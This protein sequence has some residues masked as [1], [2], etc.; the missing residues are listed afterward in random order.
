MLLL[1][2]LLSG[3]I[4]PWTYMLINEPNGRIYEA[5]ISAAQFFLVGGFL[6][7]VAAFS[8]PAPSS[9]LLALSGLL[10]ALAIGTRLVIILPV[11]FLSIM[12]A[13]RLWKTARLSPLSLAGKLFSLSLP[14]VICFIGLGWYNWARFG[15][16]T[17]TGISYQ[18][19]GMNQNDANNLFAPDYFIQNLYTYLFYPPVVT[20][21]FPFLLPKEIPII[22]LLFMAPVTMFAILSTTT[23]FRKRIPI[24]SYS[25]KANAVD[26]LNWIITS[27]TGAFIAAFG[28]LLIS[29]WT[30]IR[31]LADF[32]PALTMLS[33]LGFW[34]GY[35][36]L[37]ERPRSQRFY[38]ILGVILVIVSISM[39]L[40]LSIAVKN[41]GRT[42]F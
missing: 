2:I 23:L 30:M 39:N 12:L 6:V 28:F 3:L 41:L 11:G 15:S 25:D 33:I 8:R 4:V 17:E 37:A 20:Q 14:L 1:S 7:A 13:Y 31:Y 40:F 19:A 27:L 35:Q 5:A 29:S 16:L 42:G 22:G 24:N 34:H 32:I 10:W 18:L 38:L 9:F 21:Q 26:F 36:L